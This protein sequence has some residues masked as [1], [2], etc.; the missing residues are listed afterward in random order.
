M[1]ENQFP[2]LNIRIPS[3][4]FCVMAFGPIVSSPRLTKDEIVWTEDL[5]ER[6]RANRVHGAWFQID[7][8]S[9]GDVLATGGFVVINVDPFQLEFGSATIRTGGINS[10]LVGDDLPELFK[11]IEF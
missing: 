2:A 11:T 9:A 1:V 10:M 4:T 3:L 6:T 5:A 8:D 7:Q